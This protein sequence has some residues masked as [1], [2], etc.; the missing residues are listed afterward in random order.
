MEQERRMKI[1][2]RGWV[3]VTV[4]AVVL[5]VVVWAV[6]M[7]FAKK[8]AEARNASRPVA[9]VV[10][11][12]DTAALSPEEYV[13]RALQQ[14]E[15]DSNQA[16]NVGW[17]TSAQGSAVIEIELVGPGYAKVTM[18]ESSGDISLDNRYMTMAKQAEPFGK[19]PGSLLKYRFRAKVWVDS[20]DHLLKSEPVGALTPG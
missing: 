3:A 14:I 5:V 17:R 15:H 10:P 11:R 18:V 9:A 4:L 7:Y 12:A 20:T 8:S 16:A 2:F 19:P 6:G 1:G 13:K